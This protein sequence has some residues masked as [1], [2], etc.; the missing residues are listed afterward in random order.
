MGRT[1]KRV[2]LDFNWPIGKLWYGYKNFS[3]CNGECDDCREFA[4]AKGYITN[5]LQCPIF[6]GLDT[7][8]NPPT[9][10]GYQLWETTS[11]GS[12]ASPVFASLKELCEWCESHATTFGRYTATAAEWEEM[13]KI[14]FVHVKK[15]NAI[16]M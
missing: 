6:P 11:E 2:P 13:L 3:S 10:E 15:G 16:F 1:L 12:P 9:G 8:R 4:R 5:K 14:D 7:L